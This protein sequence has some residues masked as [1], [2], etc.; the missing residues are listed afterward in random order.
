MADGGRVPSDVAAEALEGLRREACEGW[1][2]LLEIGR[3]SGRPVVSEAMVA[4]ASRTLGE[5]YLGDEWGYDLSDECLVEV[6][7]AMVRAGAA[8]G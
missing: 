1:L 3:M 5:H 4:A 2:D 6:F 7:W 8:D